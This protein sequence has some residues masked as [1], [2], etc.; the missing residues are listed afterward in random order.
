MAQKRNP[1]TAR[2]SVVPLARSKGKSVLSVW[3]G[4]TVYAAK[5]GTTKAL[6]ALKKRLVARSLS[7]TVKRG[8]K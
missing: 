1:E 4:N 5:V 2:V 3:N 8:S 6:N 7:K